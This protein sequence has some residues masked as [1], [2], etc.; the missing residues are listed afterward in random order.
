MIDELAFDLL[1]VVA[2]GI[3][4]ATYMLGVLL[5]PM[6]GVVVGILLLGAGLFTVVPRVKW[7]VAGGSG[8]LG[9]LLAGVVVPRFVTRFTGVADELTLSL[10]LSGLVILL[11]VVSL[12]V[13]TF[14][15]PAT[16][17][18]GTTN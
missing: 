14:T 17:W 8:A 3:A 12:H 18:P 13:T 7:V 1:L 4:F 15:R 16:L 2:T 11:T 5:D 10:L 6:A 9:V